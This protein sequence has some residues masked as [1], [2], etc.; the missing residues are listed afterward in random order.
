M[1][2]TL[3]LTLMLMFYS[4][5]VSESRLPDVDLDEGLRYF[6]SQTSQT[7]G[8]SEEIV[9]GIIQVE[10]QGR[11]NARGLL[12]EAGLM[13]IR[14]STAR[15]FT[16]NPALTAWELAEPYT[17]ISIGVK[18]FGYL[19]RLS[20]GNVRNALLCYNR[21]IGRVRDDKRNGIN[22]DNGYPGRVLR[23]SRVEFVFR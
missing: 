18:Y 23:A 12:D 3:A 4:V 6:I 7:N 15:N 1:I 2:K 11:T 19:L 13:Q 8:I 17:N 5:S 10:S 20:G 14:L 16:G 9:Y 21:G 22:P